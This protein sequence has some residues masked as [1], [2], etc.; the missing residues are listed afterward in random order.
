MD[1]LT[2]NNNAAENMIAISSTD[3][4]VQVQ[5][6]Q[7]RWDYILIYILLRFL[8]GGGVGMYYFTFWFIRYKCQ[9]ILYN[10]A[11]FVIRCLW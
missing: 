6:L 9:K 8:Q 11:L 2:I 5:K 7:F 10:H 4:T 3:N 1:S